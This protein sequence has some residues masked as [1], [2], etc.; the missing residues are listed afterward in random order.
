MGGN[1]S[2]KHEEEPERDIH[3]SPAPV[4]KHMRVKTQ[5]WIPLP[6]NETDEEEPDKSDE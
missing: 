3:I 1:H 5:G 2:M 4:V 6:V